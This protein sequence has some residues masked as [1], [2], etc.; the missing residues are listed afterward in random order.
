MWA[1]TKVVV[2]R[3]IGLALIVG[4]FF[5]IRTVVIWGDVVEDV[6]QAVEPE[7]VVQ[8]NP[9]VQQPSTPT[10]SSIDIAPIQP[11]PGS[12]ESQVETYSVDPFW[13]ET[14]N[15]SYNSPVANAFGFDPFEKMYE[16]ICSFS[17]T[18]CYKPLQ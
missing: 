15:N 6:A 3:A 1:I 9:V 17:S 10:P 7:T 4:V 18:Y 16:N 14:R 12:F 5:I 8:P 11:N 13:I 2:Y